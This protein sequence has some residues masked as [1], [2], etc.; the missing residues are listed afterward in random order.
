M[1]IEVPE[2]R[3][4]D[5]EVLFAVQ[6]RNEGRTRTT[7]SEARGPRVRHFVGAALLATDEKPEVA[8]IRTVPAVLELW[9]LV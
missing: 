8:S 4:V 5:D 2:F 7:G 3:I 6:A 9:A 1:T